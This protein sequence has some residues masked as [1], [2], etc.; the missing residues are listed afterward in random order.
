MKPGDTIKLNILNTAPDGRG[1]GKIDQFVVFVIGACEGDL[2]LAKILTVHK[3]Y[4]T[5]AAAQVLV[6]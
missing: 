4:A 1:I 5:A 3:T 6:A 2:V